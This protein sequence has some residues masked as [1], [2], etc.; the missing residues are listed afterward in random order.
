MTTRNR[1]AATLELKEIDDEGRFEG[2]ASVFNK[3]DLGGDM[4]LPG[5]YKKTLALMKKQKRV[6][7]LLWRHQQ[8][9]VMGGFEEL[10]ETAKGLKVKGRIVPDLSEYSMKAYRLMK[11]GLA[12]GL[13]IGYRVNDGCAERVDGVRKIKSLDLFEISFTPVAMDPYANVTSVKHLSDIRGKLAAGERLSPREWELVLKEQCNLT[14]SE[15]E[16][17]VRVNLKKG[18]VAPGKS[19][20]G[21]DLVKELKSLI[22]K[23]EA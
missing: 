5:A 9:E 13:S 11:S 18:S 14:N 15:A 10:E 8:E 4:I 7:P 19:H 17:A 20:D 6:I 22:V 2:L 1:Q 12:R 3:V 23:T 21:F 16:R